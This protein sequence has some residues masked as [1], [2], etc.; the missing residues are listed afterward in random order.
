MNMDVPP[1]DSMIDLM[2]HHADDLV[3]IDSFH[4]DFVCM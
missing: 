4:G 1:Y 3:H 2:Y